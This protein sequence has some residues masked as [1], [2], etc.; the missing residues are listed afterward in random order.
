[1]VG[2]RVIEFFASLLKK[3][4]G[5]EHIAARYGG[6]EMVLILIVLTQQQVIELVDS[7]RSNLA[8]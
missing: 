1:M 2:D 8:D 6:E 3:Y 5:N 4:S 7:I